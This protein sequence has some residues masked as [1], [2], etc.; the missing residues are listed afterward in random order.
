MPDLPPD[1]AAVLAALATPPGVPGSGRVRYGAAMALNRAGA[2][3]DAVLEVY[4][5]CSPLDA[6]DPAG[7]MAARGL[8]MPEGA[9]PLPATRLAALVEAA[10]LYL[11]TLPGPG[12]AEVRA[13][14]AAA[15][16]QPQPRLSPENPVVAAHLDRALQAV[17][18]EPALVAAIR[19]AAD[20]LP[21]V[22]YDLYPRDRIGDFAEAH[23]FAEVIGP[24]A[25]LPAADFSLGVFLI[26]PDVLYRDHA[27]PA[28][29]L[30]APLTGP[31]GW[32][33]G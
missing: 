32:R 20:A 26:A 27:H 21:W 29:E 23:A 12:V 15:R 30:Y 9:A 24:G 10:D 3:S 1:R 8:P 4:R 31:H 7:L 14:I 5:I 13:G 28:P 2:I 33:F 19:A 6:E 16:G 22:T 25:P 11:S 18:G 17:P